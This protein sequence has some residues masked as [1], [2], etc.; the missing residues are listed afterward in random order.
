[1]D[2]SGHDLLPWNTFVFTPSI[3]VG[4]GYG[5]NLNFAFAV[6]LRPV[7]N[8]VN[9]AGSMNSVGDI[10]QLP[11]QVGQLLNG[12]NGGILGEVDITEGLEVQGNVTAEFAITT[13][14]MED[15]PGAGGLASGEGWNLDAVG[16]AGICVG[17]EVADNYATDNQF[18]TLGF[19]FGAGEGLEIDTNLYSEADWIFWSQMD[20]SSCLQ[21]P[22]IDKTSGDCPGP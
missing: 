20:G 17:A 2:P 7:N 4:L 21:V 18:D 19:I 3:S 16:C 22:S 9:F 5:I 1:V 8:F 15:L 6:D 13:D 12:L 11:A 14:T 10:T